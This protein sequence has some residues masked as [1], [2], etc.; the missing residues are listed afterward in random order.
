[1]LAA[2]VAGGLLAVAS[3]AAPSPRLDVKPSSQSMNGASATATTRTL[4]LPAASVSRAFTMSEPA[5]VIL[6]NQ[7]TVPHGM[8]VVVDATIP[9]VAGVSVSSWTRP[10]APS[11]SCETTGDLDV[12]TQGEEWCPMPAA[13]WHVRVVKRAGPAGLV[14]FVLRVAPPPKH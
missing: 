7:V 6:L 9:G 4:W 3:N 13:R 10:V 8:R 1:M 11:A 2:G 12:C 5:G 14:R